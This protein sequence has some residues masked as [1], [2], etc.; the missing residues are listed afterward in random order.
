MRFKTPL[1][2]AAMAAVLVHAVGLLAFKVTTEPDDGNRALPEAYLQY[3]RGDASARDMAALFDTAPV[4]L[5]TEWN[6]ASNYTVPGIKEQGIDLFESFPAS[7]QLNAVTLEEVIG[8]VKPEMTASA[9]I[10]KD[11][12][13]ASFETFGR[14]ES[15]VAVSEVQSGL[16]EVRDMRNGELVRSWN[17]PARFDDILRNDL[18]LAV[19]QVTVDVLGPVGEP[20][21]LQGTGAG[22]TDEALR[23][24]LSDPLLFAGFSS[25]YYRINVGP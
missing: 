23:D 10:L 12:L 18:F 8:P 2:V 7:I 1:L 24:Y 22:E 9:D 20:L 5:P 14:E 4:F 3:P 21:L 11:G 16:V 13:L 17:L 15:S 6:Y 19:F 25:G